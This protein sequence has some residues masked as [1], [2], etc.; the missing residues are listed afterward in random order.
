LCAL[1]KT[2]TWCDIRCNL[3]YGL[4]DSESRILDNIVVY[5]DNEN[6]TWNFEEIPEC[7]MIEQPNSVEE[8]ITITLDSEYMHCGDFDDERQAEVMKSLKVGIIQII[9][10]K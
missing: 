1:N 6:R 5:C 10:I 2:H 8:I 4:I 3:G 7:S 9:T